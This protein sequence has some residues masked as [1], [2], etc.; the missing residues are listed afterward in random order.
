M[1][2]FDVLLPDPDDQGYIGFLDDVMSLQDAAKSGAVGSETWRHMKAF[3]MNVIDVPADSRAEVEAIVRSMSLD[4]FNAVFAKITEAISQ[5][6]ETS[7][8]SNEPLEQH[9]EEAKRPRRRYGS[10]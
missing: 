1:R 6:K 10:V 3:V 9:F 4:E 2:Q 5:K 8:P 7:P